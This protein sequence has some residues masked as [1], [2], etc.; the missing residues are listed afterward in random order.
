M[1]G[2]MPRVKAV[3]ALPP[4][5][6]EE[7]LLLKRSPS[8]PSPRKAKRRSVLDATL[9]SKEHTWNT[10]PEVLDPVRRVAPIGLDPCSNP[11]SLVKA[12][13]SWSLEGGHNGL[14]P[15][16]GG[17]GLVF[18]NPP[19][20]DDLPVWVEKINKEASVS[21]ALGNFGSEIVLLAPARTDAKWF[22]EGV[23]H[24]VRVVLFWKGRISFLQRGEFPDGSSA[25]PAF[26]G[27]WG[28]RPGAFI[29]E[30]ETL[31]RVWTPNGL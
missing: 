15:S 1:G 24:R 7:G 27:Y 23:L 19:Y 21:A 22:Q 11:F 4:P 30:V 29:R 3:K 20:G 17:H 12:R 6:E 14:L 13:T 26:L 8:E 31:G 16:W 10:P 28:P 18:V 5:E 25:F 2:T 9:S